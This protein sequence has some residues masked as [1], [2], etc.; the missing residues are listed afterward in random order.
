MGKAL[1]VLTG[2]ASMMTAAISSGCLRIALATTSRLFQ[3][4][5]YHLLGRAW[6]LAE[7]FG[8]GEG[9]VVGA[10]VL[11]VGCDAVE[12]GVGPAVIVALELDNEGSTGVGP[13]DPDGREDGLGAGAAVANH[14]G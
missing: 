7:G 3:G 9:G 13:S 1:L 11:D 4:K 2:I 10:R 5:D 14:L 12:N 8:D 6:G